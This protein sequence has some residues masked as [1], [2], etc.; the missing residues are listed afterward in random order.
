VGGGYN[1][2]GFVGPSY[3]GGGF[4]SAGSGFG[5]GGGSVGGNYVT[6]FGGF[7]YELNDG[8]FVPDEPP[9]EP[10]E[11]AYENPPFVEIPEVRFV[12]YR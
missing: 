7:A 8:P 2:S 1:G 6:G 9:P 3:V 12:R 11:L 4:V 10:Q 5:V